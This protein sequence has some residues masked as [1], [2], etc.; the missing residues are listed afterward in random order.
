M[1]SAEVQAKPEPVST[2]RILGMDGSDPFANKAQKETL[3]S[4][5][6]RDPAIAKQLSDHLG[7]LPALTAKAPEGGFRS[8]L[9]SISKDSKLSFTEQ[10]KATA[11]VL[12]LDLAVGAPSALS[13]SALVYRSSVVGVTALNMMHSREAVSGIEAERES[14]KIKERFKSELGPQTIKAIEAHCMP[15]K[16]DKTRSYLYNMA[17]QGI[18]GVISGSVAAPFTGGISLPVMTLAGMGNGALH[19]RTSLA[20]Q[21]SRCEVKEMREKLL[22]W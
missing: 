4:M 15:S 8:E 2:L 18:V 9:D 7:N 10:L 19:A 16:T 17:E 11:G 20:L 12:A 21:Q 13:P 5:L 6:K 3:D 22:K 1:G 14:S